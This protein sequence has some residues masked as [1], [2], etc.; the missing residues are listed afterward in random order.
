MISWVLA[1]NRL[2]VHNMFMVVGFLGPAALE[3]ALLKQIFVDTTVYKP[4]E[5]N[6]R[7]NLLEDSF[8]S[9]HQSSSLLH[10]EDTNAWISQK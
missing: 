6:N 7:L 2:I 4:L 8:F 9:T 1:I 3:K 5:S 10:F